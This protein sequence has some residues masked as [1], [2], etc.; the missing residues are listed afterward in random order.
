M[1]LIRSNLGASFR[2]ARDARVPPVRA[3]FAVARGD[4]A[5]GTPPASSGKTAGRLA[6]LRRAIETIER[7]NRE[8]PATVAFGVAEIDRFLP[9]GGLTM[10]ALH[11]VGAAQ[12]GAKPAAFG[13]AMALAA[14]AQGARRGPMVLIL[15]RR[16]CKDFG[17]PY[18]H[19]LAKLGVDAGRLIVVETRSDKEALWAIEETLKSRAELA[20]VVG[21]PGSDR[22][23]ARHLTESRRLSLAAAAR[24]TP[25]V[26]VSSAARAQASAA[27][28]RWRIATAGSAKGRSGSEDREP[29]ARSRWSVTL[30]RCRNGRTGQWLI[31][32]DHGTNRFHLAQGLADH[33]P[34]A[35]RGEESGRLLRWRAG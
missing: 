4:D 31:E 17:M 8:A 14:L 2:E 32:W 22:D 28:T 34:H 1:A 23:P 12:H 16:S 3:A 26:L 15:S 9:G 19:G 7:G 24:G 13:F 27:V 18:G 35:G 20:M 33:A 11:E 5:A 30:D 10:G 25:L 21:V 29:F 6:G